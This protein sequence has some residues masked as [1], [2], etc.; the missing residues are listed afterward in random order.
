MTA[1]LRACRLAELATQHEGPLTTDR[2]EGPLAMRSVLEGQWASPA[3]P[4]SVGVVPAAELHHVTDQADQCEA[5]ADAEQPPSDG[6]A[7][8][9]E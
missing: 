7:Q 8:K 9:D 3:L 4:L 2:G 1:G 5:D 6:D